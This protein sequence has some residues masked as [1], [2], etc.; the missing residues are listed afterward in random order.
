MPSQHK[1]NPVTFRPGTE[2]GDPAGD[3]DWLYAHA[4]KTGRK[5]GEIL[6]EALAD[7]R[8]RHD[9]TPDEPAA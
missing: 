3:R 9:L 6:S 8:A 1:R 7:Y 4:E 2:P 5:V